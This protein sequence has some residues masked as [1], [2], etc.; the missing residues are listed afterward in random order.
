[1]TPTHLRH[2][3]A[4]QQSILMGV[5]AFI[6]SFLTLLGLVVYPGWVKLFGLLLGVLAVFFIYMCVRTATLRVRVD[7]DGVWEPNPF[8]LTHVTRWTEI[9]QIRK[10]LVPG[11]VSF[12]GVQIVYKDGEERDI[13]ALKM[14]AK[15]AGS[16]DAV[17]EWVETL[18]AAK[19]QA[20]S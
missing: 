4:T 11:R 8:R 2:P 14:Q 13:L 1:M 12:V 3:R 9:S 5:L 7:D 17:A 6:S 19:A 15:A 20:L 18:R 16:E 10:N